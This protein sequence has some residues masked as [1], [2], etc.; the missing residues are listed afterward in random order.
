MIDASLLSA[1]WLLVEPSLL[2]YVTLGIVLGLI[3][4]ALP[5]MSTPLALAL[6][7]LPSFYMGPVAALVFLSSVYTGSVYGGGIT[8]ILFNIPGTPG[9]LA[10]T[11]D[12]YPMTRKG[13]QSEALGLGLASSV[14][15]MF[16]SYLVIFLFMVPIASLVLRFGPPEMLMLVI[17]SLAV[18]GFVGGSISKS[19]V[20]GAFGLLIG[21]IGTDGMLGMPRGTFGVFELIEGVPIIPVLVGLFA[22]SELL[23]LLRR[24]FIVDEY[25]H[26]SVLQMALGVLAGVKGVWRYKMTALTSSAIGVVV[27]LLPAAGGT[28]SA[29]IAYA[30]VSRKD[31]HSFGKGNPEGVVAPESANN[32]SEAGAM[33]T[34]MAF[35]IPGSGATA[36][37][38]SAFMIHGLNPGPYL[39][40]DSMDVVYVILLSNFV[41]AAVLFVCGVLFVGLLC[42]VVLVPTAVVIPLVAVSAIIGTVALRNSMVDLWVALAFG[43]IGYLMRRAN[44]PLIAIV[45]GIVLGSMLEEELIRTYQLFAFRPFDLLTRPIFVTLLVVTAGFLLSPLFKAVWR[46]SRSRRG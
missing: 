44:Y 29:L 25:K 7:L 27:G 30:R 20:A 38:I 14:F 40:R 9:A 17:F 32:A 39:L 16:L 43:V 15:G 19:L 2:V 5:G 36:V 33:A 42:R 34:M 28:L 12:G 13:R 8:A 41:Q 22:F 26:Q 45:L 31:E 46:R 10:S 37:L 18:I 1:A 4:G 11:F 3:F 24:Q 35:G 6:M 23:F 21:L